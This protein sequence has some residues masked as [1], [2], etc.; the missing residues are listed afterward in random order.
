MVVSK[1][2]KGQDELNVGDDWLSTTIEKRWKAY[3]QKFADDDK[4]MLL[5]MANTFLHKFPYILFV[6]LPFFALI[7]K[8]LYIR[9]KHFYYNDHAVFTL[10]HYIFSFILLIFYLLLSE[11]YDWLQWGIL[12][13]FAGII[14]LSGGVYLAFALK[15]FYKQ[16]WA[17]TLSKFLLLNVLGLFVLILIF[18]LFLIFSLFQL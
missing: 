16:G 12:R 4:A 17:K 10:Y 14:L 11:M 13:F 9:R 18:I 2:Q 1:I 15:K 6:S 3:R 8:L 5:D 7:L